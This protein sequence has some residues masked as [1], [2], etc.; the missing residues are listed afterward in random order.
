MA[1][2]GSTTLKTVYHWHLKFSWTAT[3]NVAANTSAVAW[4]VIFSID[5]GWPIHA[6]VRTGSV[7]VNGAKT[8]F[9]FTATSEGGSIVVARGTTTIA[10]DSD[11]NKTFGVSAVLPLNFTSGTYGYI[12][13]LTGSA[14]Y[15]LNKIAR[16]STFITNTATVEMGGNLTVLITA[17]NAAFTHKLNFTF[18]SFHG[19]MVDKPETGHNINVH[20]PLAT[21]A[22]IIYNNTTG[23]GSL[24]LDTYNG[25]TKI[26]TATQKLTLT[27]PAS[28]VPNIESVTLT[29]T[30]TVP[31]KLGV[32]PED[33]LFV[34][35]VSTLHFDV[36]AGGAYG[37]TINQY[38]FTIDDK[39]YT[40]N[41]ATYDLLSSIGTGAKSIT[42]GVIDTRGRKATATKDIV[43]TAY[44]KP[45][46]TAASITRDSNG[47][48]DTVT[49][50]KTV[51]IS[52]LK[53]GTVEKNPYTVVT[54]YKLPSV[55]TWTNAKTEN[56]T[57]AASFQI[58]LDKLKGYD[59][60]IVVK[61]KLF[62]TSFGTTIPTAKTLLHLYKDEGIGI[63]KFYEENHGVL[64]VGGDSHFEGNIFVNGKTLL[65]MFY[66]IGTIYE[67]VNSE[68]PSSFMGGT[69][70]RFGN[71]RVTVGVDEND[72]DLA[73]PSIEG[74]LTNPL[75]SHWHTIT[76]TTRR[77]GTSGKTNTL[78]RSID[79]ANPVTG[80]IAD[81]KA[82]TN[83]QNAHHANWQPFAT[84]YRWLRT[85]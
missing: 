20:F 82:A 57:S 14:S 67:S 64:D 17:A 34:D 68:N 8:N 71:G 10:H 1:L 60:R 61:D 73:S 83:G 69:W 79:L 53:L 25:A 42:V 28:V 56:S 11:G 32:E 23:W 76:G 12:S 51:V 78:A 27:V 77:S 54:E 24:T 13:S 44:Q 35:G 75:T 5:S 37:S 39:T 15:S 33:G 55:A 41:S 65:N 48:A 59:V 19:V 38:N 58:T 70:E 62:D 74:G 63:G 85:A 22:P 7:T 46:L 66:P 4:Q 40:S 47:A 30:S 21:F 36:A 43:I 29:D 31:S 3:Q 9:N 6:G 52:S 81:V 80:T 2:S 49:V 26:G 45:S 16:A 50:K 18:G 84:V 72:A